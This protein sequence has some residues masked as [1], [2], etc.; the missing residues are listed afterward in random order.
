MKIL[1]FGAAGLLGRHLR[2]ELCG[3]QLTA[4]DHAQADITDA[5]RLDELF[6]ARWDAVVNAAAICDFDACENDPESTG[7]VNRDAPLDLARRCNA[8]GATFVQF[9]SDYVFAGDVDRPLTEDDEPAPLSVYGHQKAALEREI[10]RLCPSG[11][12]LRIAWLY[13]SGGRTF[14]SRLPHLLSAQ[15]VLR[16]AAAKRGRCLYARD[17]ALWVRRLLEAGQT[18]L[19]NLVNDGNTSWEE[20]ARACL[21]RM[22]SLGM[23]PRCAR[24]EEIAYGDLGPNWSKRPRWSCLDIAKLRAAHPPGPRPWSEALD[25]FLRQ[26]KQFAAPRP[27]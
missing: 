22:R 26:Q 27:L 10:P 13:G 11:L 7:R 23:A 4:L 20:F 24:I 3:H 17:A 21:G 5:R 19:I 1:L 9:S 14:M 18:G 25:D 15:E 8:A 2:Q 16:V 12:V 6:G